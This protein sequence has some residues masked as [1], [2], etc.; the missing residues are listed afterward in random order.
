MEKGFYD[1]PTTL[2]IDELNRAIEREAKMLSRRTKEFI[3]P[4]LNQYFSKIKRQELRILSIGC[5][6]GEDV[7]SLRDAGYNAIGVDVFNPDMEAFTGELARLFEYCNGCNFIIPQST[8]KYLDMWR[9][10]EKSKMFSYIMPT[11]EKY[12]G[13]V[14]KHSTLRKSCLAPH[15]CVLVVK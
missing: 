14:N 13:F 9:I 8:E 15:L 6:I 3:I 4:I 7:A 5:G 12:L 1:I 11:F 10:A 2:P